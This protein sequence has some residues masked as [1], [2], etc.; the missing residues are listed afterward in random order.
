MVQSRDRGLSGS[1]TGS[2]FPLLYIMG[3]SHRSEAEMSASSV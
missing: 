3:G 2:E 1:S